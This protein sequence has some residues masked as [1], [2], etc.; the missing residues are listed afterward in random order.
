MKKNAFLTFC[1]A[2]VPGC[3]QMYLGYMKRGVS[4]AFWCA[5]LIAITASSR[6]L[7]LGFLIFVI[8]AYSFFDT[9][10]LRNLSPEQKAA[11]Y[12]DFIPNSAFFS[13][14]KWSGKLNL[15]RMAGWGFVAVGALILLSNARDALFTL[16]NSISPNLANWFDYAGG[17]ILGLA[18]GAGIILI[19]I[20]MLRG[21]HRPDEDYNPDQNDYTGYGDSNA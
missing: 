8:W 10:N 18:L 19:G 13:P 11:F 16:L 2:F 6:V 15:V 20:R 5:L 7:G 14:N 9:F 21:A 17:L 3:G 12:D 4:L 1:F